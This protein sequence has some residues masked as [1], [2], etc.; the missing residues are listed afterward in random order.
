MRY[1]GLDLLRAT[2]ML[3]GFVLHAL[4]I[5][6]EPEIRAQ[7]LPE[8]QMGHVEI[9]T[10][11]W[12]IYVWIHMW[13]MPLFFVL[14]GFFAAMVIERKGAPGFLSDRA[15]RIG[16]AL[17]IFLLLFNVLADAPWGRLDHL[18]FLWFLL[19][20]SGALLILRALGAGRVFRP[21]LWL[22]ESPARLIWLLLPAIPLC[23]ATREGT[24]GHYIPE[25]LL[26]WEWR[27]VLFYSLVFALGVGLWHGRAVL[28]PLAWPRCFCLILGAATAAYIPL[29]YTV[30]VYEDWLSGLEGVPALVA[31]TLAG[32]LSA[33]TTLGFI[34]GLIGAAQALM[35]R[36][37]PILSSVVTLA[38]PLYLLHLYPV[39]GLSTLLLEQGLP[40]IATVTL[41]VFA[42][43][44]ICLVQYLIFIRYTPLNWAIAGYEKSWFKRPWRRNGS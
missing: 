11:G 12:T 44:I 19:W 20:F 43:L 15:V 36:A 7:I 13:R 33:I 28:D 14:A 17:L 2:A 26:E 27:G 39:L 25:Y 4:L 42:S 41:T 5:Y 10:L 38:F 1:H 6:D 24:I 34:F 9:S 18:W 30:T 35:T 8:T 21:L 16:G 29:L 23:M 3:L 31:L 22:F 32:T 40:E 37:S